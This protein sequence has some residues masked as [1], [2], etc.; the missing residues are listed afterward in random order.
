MKRNWRE[1]KRLLRKTLENQ[2]IIVKKHNKKQRKIK[3]KQQKKQ[4]LNSG[5]ID[6]AQ[7]LE[8][9]ISELTSTVEREEERIKNAKKQTIAKVAECYNKSL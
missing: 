5:D 2:R 1:K 3:Q 9:K 8:K 7:K 6:G 4:L